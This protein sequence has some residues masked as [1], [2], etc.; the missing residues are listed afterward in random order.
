[1]IRRATRALGGL[2]AALGLFGCRAH[3]PSE[4]GRGPDTT[5]AYAPGGGLTQRLDLFL[6]DSGTPPG[7]ATVVFTYGSGWR[8]PRQPRVARVC[9]AFRQQRFA[10]ALVAH[11][12]GDTSPFPAQAEDEAAA[13]AWVLEHIAHFGGDPTCVHL[14]GHSSGAHLAVLIAN[15]PRYLR[16]RGHTPS[17]LA[18]V[19]GLST[20]TDLRRRADGSGFGDALMGGRGADTFRRDT[21]LMADASP[22]R[23]V[24]RTGPPMLLVV[25]S[26]DFPMLR[27]DAATFVRQARAAGRDATWLLADGRDHMGTVAALVEPDDPVKA[28]V[29]QF[30]RRASRHAPARA[31]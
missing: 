26:G 1:M 21:A 31:P 30:L 19:V 11:R 27:E 16:A 25:G 15:D 18:S 4:G 9:E 6:P 29:L 13:T 22:V 12:L 7:F 17:E 14:V 5:V 28:R 3:G 8:A 23:H 2:V 24:A 10:C 20:P